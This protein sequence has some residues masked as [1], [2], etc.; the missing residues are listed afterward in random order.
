MALKDTRKF[1]VLEY[2]QNG[3]GTRVWHARWNGADEITVYVGT[4]SEDEILVKR[5]QKIQVIK[6]KKNMRVNE[7]HQTVEEF[8][9]SMLEA[10]KV[11]GQQW[12]G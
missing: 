8:L 12:N 4:V 9:E 10:E 7:F 5:L 1:E 3:D 6:G 2:D 11:T